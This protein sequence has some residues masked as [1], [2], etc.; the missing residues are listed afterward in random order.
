MLSFF[1]LIV[2][3]AVIGLIILGIISASKG[4]RIPSSGHASLECPHCGQQTRAGRHRCEHCGED[5]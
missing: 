3:V 1:G 5:L 4:L 2:I